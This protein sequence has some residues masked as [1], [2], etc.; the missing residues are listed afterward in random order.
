MKHLHLKLAILIVSILQPITNAVSPVLSDLQRAFPE[1]D[2]GWILQLLSLPSLVAVPVSLLSGTLSARISKKT[3][4]LC[5][6]ALITLAGIAPMLI[7]SF[8]LIMITRI[9]V[10]IGVGIVIPFMTGLI[11]DFFEG[12]EKNALFGFQG[13][14]VNMGSVCYLLLGGIL[15]AV[16]WRLNF[17]VFFIGAAIFVVVFR[18][19]PEPPA[20]T[21]KT[22]S[23]MSLKKEIYFVILLMF[24]ISTL[25]FSFFSQINP[26]QNIRICQ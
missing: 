5:G 19:L 2:N 14:F 13:A 11:T 12:H 18:M 6:T 7:H 10:G 1:V 8:V 15:G 24:M 20:V 16:S 22:S 4:L 26:W 25:A 9:L 21:E 17:A 3:L 23:P